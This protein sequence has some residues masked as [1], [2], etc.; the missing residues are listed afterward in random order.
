MELYK[1]L[2]PERTDVL[3]SL[4]IRF[5]Q[6][7]DFN[8]PFEFRPVLPSDKFFDVP[9]AN[10]LADDPERLLPGDWQLEFES[11]DVE[12]Q[13]YAVEEEEFLNEFAA[14]SQRKASSQI[15]LLCLSETPASLTMWAHYTGAHEGFVLAFNA[16]HEFF[17]QSRRN[18][19]LGQL[20]KVRYAQHRPHLFRWTHRTRPSFTDFAQ[21]F[22]FTKSEEWS[23]EKEWRMMFPLQSTAIMPNSVIGRI[24]LFSVPPDAITGVILGARCNEATENAVREVLARDDEMRHVRL[25]RAVVSGSQFRLSF[26]NA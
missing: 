5:T 16:E 15:G 2:L 12:R 25:Q 10:G 9:L 18:Y 22:M 8:D 14:T 26:V 7:L 24:H 1:Y 4:S 3:T 23:Y 19:A 20:W 13:E 6:P 17:R 11:P 21:D